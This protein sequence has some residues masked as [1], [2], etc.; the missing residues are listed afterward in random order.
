MSSL[1]SSE[2]ALESEGSKTMNWKM[3]LFLQGDRVAVVM[4]VGLYDGCEG[5]GWIE[6]KGRGVWVG[7]K[8]GARGTKE[9]IKGRGPGG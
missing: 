8:G 4:V 3:H 6:V 9:R 1:S 2:V 7:R 5:G